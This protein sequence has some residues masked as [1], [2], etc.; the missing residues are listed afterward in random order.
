MGSRT[1]A[2]ALRA[3]DELVCG[4]IWLESLG[5]FPKRPNPAFPAPWPLRLLNRLLGGRNVVI[6]SNVRSVPFG[7]RFLAAFLRAGWFPFIPAAAPRK[8]LP[9]IEFSDHRCY[10]DAG[11]RALMV[12]NTAFLRNPHYHQRT[13]RLAT[14][15]LDRMTRLCRV[16]TRTVARL[17][18]AGKAHPPAPIPPCSS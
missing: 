14:L 13:D 9:V 4:M 7:L 16:L 2:E 12:T 18:G 8:L 10:W 6:V 3:R 17:A 15:D 11:Y 5:Y 1:H